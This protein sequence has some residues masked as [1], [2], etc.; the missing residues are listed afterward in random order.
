[1]TQDPRNNSYKRAY[2][3]L[4]IAQS[5]SGGKAEYTCAEQHQRKV[6]E[7]FRTDSMKEQLRTN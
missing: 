6:G 2:T 5:G 7:H 1:M 4:V 3:G